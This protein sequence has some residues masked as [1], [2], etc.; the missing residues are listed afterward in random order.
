MTCYAPMQFGDLLT[1]NSVN[2]DR[3]TETY[4]VAFYGTYLTKWPD[5]QTVVR[6]PT[7]VM[8]GYVLGKVEGNGQDW[9]GHVSAVTVS[10][11]FRRVG[12]G[13][14]LMKQL[15]DVSAN[16]HKGYFV[17]LFVRRSNAGAKSMY[18]KLGYVVY[19]TVLGYYQGGNPGENAVHGRSEDA[20]DMRKALPRN[21]ERSVSAVIPLSKPVKPAD[22]EWH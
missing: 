12:L 22:L 21:A 11:C 1:F 20:L 10:S 15:E 9:H 5:Y 6:H 16:V 19:R 4:S 17:D 3:F 18:E 2:I 14:Q 7:G 8:M 13:E